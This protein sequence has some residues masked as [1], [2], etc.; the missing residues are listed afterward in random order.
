MAQRSRDKTYLGIDSHVLIAYLI[1]DH[2]DHNATKSL[3]Q[4][5]HA[6]NPTVLHEAYHT[7]VFRLRRKPEE[8]VKILTDY[9]D[10]VLCLSMNSETVRWGLK[11]AL[12]HSLG[13]RDALILSSYGL[14][15]EVKTFTTMDRKLLA[16]KR[17]RIAGK[18]LPI[19]PTSEINR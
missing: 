18:I 11:V 12:E 19:V 15:K 6:V 16:L 8:L 2:P 14:S 1:P 10:F 4:Q 13:G 5:Y 3:T 7:C 17:V 9:M